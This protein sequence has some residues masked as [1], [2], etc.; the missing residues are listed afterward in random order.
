[1]RIEATLQNC[2][3]VQEFASAAANWIGKT[4]TTVGSAIAEG[5]HK[6]AE[7]VR[8]YFENLKSFAQENSQAIF[9][10]SLGAMVGAFALHMINSIFCRGTNRPP[11]TTTTGTT[12]T[13][14]V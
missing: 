1:M 9:I 11:E 3:G 6:V 12:A 14:T 8:P 7:F 2:S 13:T 4:A 10:F 5:A